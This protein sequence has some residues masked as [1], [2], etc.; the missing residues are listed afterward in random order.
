VAR[1]PSVVSFHCVIHEKK[2][3]PILPGFFSSLLRSRALSLSSLSQSGRR[4]AP[5]RSPA[6]CLPR[7]PRA[8]PSCCS[9]QKPMCSPESS[10]LSSIIN[11]ARRSR[12]E[13]AFSAK[14][15]HTS[16][17]ILLRR[18]PHVPLPRPLHLSFVLLP[19]LT[20]SPPG[21]CRWFRH[22]DRRLRGLLQ[23]PLKGPKCGPDC[24]ATRIPS[25]LAYVVNWL[26]CFESHFVHVFFQMRSG[27]L[28]SKTR[29]YGV[30]CVSDDACYCQS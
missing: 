12:N 26:R 28:C 7:R 27:G 22:G 29:E 25:L 11:P 20:I 30:G 13:V 19:G 9:S 21:P 24:A 8:G 16:S 1:E 17:R 2:N 10:T 5:T 23:H 18:H 14:V 15:N 6:T 4:A 3:L